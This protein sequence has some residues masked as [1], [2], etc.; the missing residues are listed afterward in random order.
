VTALPHQ[1]S[2]YRVVSALGVGGFA[3]VVSARD[4]AL[5]SHVAIKVLDHEHAQDDVTRQR[6][7]REAQLL[8][9]VKDSHVIAIHDIGEM[10]DGRPFLVME[11]AT[12]GSLADRIRPGQPADEASVRTTITALAS[13]LGALHAIG[14]IHRDVKPGNLLIVADATGQGAPGATQHRRGL[15]ADGERVVVGDLGLAK[16]QERTEGAPTILGGT[17]LFR[18]PEQVR[19]GEIIGPAADVFGAT[20]VVWNLLTGEPPPPESALEAQ[21]ATAPEAWRSFFTRGLALDPESRFETMRDWERAALDALDADTGTRQVGF[22]A[23]ETGATCPYKGLNSFQPQDAAFFFGRETLVDELVTRL[24]ASRTLVVGGPSGSGKSSV[25]R[26]GLV[27]AIEA[28]AL[29]GSQNWPV[30]LMSP[31]DQ[32][33]D[34]IA[35]QLRRLAPNLEPPTRDQLLADPREA[36]R[37]LPP[38]TA[39]LIVID[40]FEEIFTHDLDP[41]E[42]AALLDVL[43]ALTS[44]QDLQIRVVLALRSDFYS[45]C[46]S[47]PWL[48]ECISTNQVLVG[49]MRRHDLRQ[50]IEGPARRAG[51]RLEPGLADAFLDEAGDDAG[52]LPLVSHA[53]METWI[54]RRGS[55]LTLEGFRAAGG[56]G[57]AIAQ[58]AESAYARL[59]PSGRVAARRLF[60]R[61]VA[62]GDDAPDTRRRL[63]WDELDPDSEASDLIDTWTEDRLL[64]SDDRG[65]ELVHETLIHAW[66]RL[67]EWIDD[68]RTDLRIEQRVERAAQEWHQ[69]DRD[70]DL[71][72]RGAPLAS[73]LDWRERTSVDVSAGAAAFLDASVEARDAEDQANAAAERRRRMV[74]RVAFTSLSL[75]SVLALTAGAVAVVALRQSQDNEAEAEA[76]FARALATQ[77]ESLATS[78]PKLALALAAESAARMDP[79]PAEAQAAMVTARATLDASDIVPD[80]EP[81]PVGDVL[82]TL[83]TPDGSA[84]VTGARDGTVQLVDA[85]SGDTIATMSGPSQGIEEAVIDP[86]GR[87][88]VAVGADG[89][90]RWDLDDPGPGEQVDRPS[91]ALWSVAFSHDGSELATAAENGVVTVYSTETWEPYGT[92]YEADVDFL[93]VTFTLDDSVLLAGTGDGRVFVWD[94]ATRTQKRPPIAAHGTNDVWEL[95]VDP[96]GRTVATSSSDGT[97]RLWS[98]DTGELVASPFTDPSG[99][100]VVS[101]TTG[102]VWSED[103]STLYAGGNDGHVHKWDVASGMVVDA[104]TVGHNDVITDAAASADRSRLATLGRDQTI[105]VWDIRGREPVVATV[106]DLGVPL[107]S[108]DDDPDDAMVAV[109]DRNGAVHLWRDGDEVVLTGLEGRVRGLAVLPDGRVVAGAEDGSVHMW[110]RDGTELAASE[111]V[112]GAAITGMALRPSGESLATSSSDGVVRVWSTDDLELLAETA[113][114]GVD[115][116]GVTVLRSGE[117]VAAYRDGRVRFWDDDGTEARAP[118]QVDSDGDSVFSVA[119]SPDE[120]VLAAA[121][122]TEGVTLWDVETGRPRSQLNGQPVDPLDVVFTPDGTALVSSNRDGVVAIWNVATGQGLGPRFRYHT[123]AIWQMAMTPTSVV[124]TASED[125]TV[126][127]LD[128]LDIDRACELAAD[129][130][131][132]PARERYLGNRELVGCAD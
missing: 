48:A 56:V 58:S 99:A 112:P 29:P 130:L 17:P 40:Q 121:A 36:R 51:L 118:L 86:S 117:L 23:P 109:G 91:G 55:V 87:W 124:Y 129:A 52:S 127:R 65:V 32:P 90:W 10:D 46:A 94:L 39:G 4:E 14:V 7:V 19:K 69:Q 33:L 123:H 70:P 97:T 43:V 50:A 73:I 71:L 53:L 81:I 101:G 92:Q 47:I 96:T 95:A 42:R 9:R 5:D 132:G 110:A 26:A 79:V 72:Y 59:G 67:R 12:G 122:A 98:V 34:E 66:P 120:H 37:W 114:P 38:G 2:R 119:L 128:A 105:R 74:R 21:L 85:T 27:P 63:S 115:A 60:L 64:T 93:S 15:L 24:Q 35:A 82:T 102:L 100:R 13:G 89:L 45:D 84:V 1:I 125:G 131:S 44:S 22:R 54:R 30:I 25:V 8:R 106:A 18:A 88:L 111:A 77:A 62:L 6:F 107:F 57:G 76:R 28:G 75:L 49:P 31:G 16:D 113:S 68:N 126:G 116:N 80:S 83:M 78:R 11:L 3:T 20:G 108:V 41:R 104:S 103:G 61:M